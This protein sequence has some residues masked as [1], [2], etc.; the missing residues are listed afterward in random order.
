VKIA[1]DYKKIKTRQLAEELALLVY[2]KEFQK[3]EVE[4]VPYIRK[5]WGLTSEVQ[6]LNCREV[7]AMVDRPMLI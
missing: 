7:I 6:C 4:L 2:P 3:S 1:K 5:V